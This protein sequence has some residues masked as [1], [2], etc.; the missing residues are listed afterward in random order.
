MITIRHSFALSLTPVVRFLIRM[1]GAG[2]LVGC[3]TYDAP[4]A[5]F[6]VTYG[7]F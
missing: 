4:M 6:C 5:S 1:G 7:R 2:A 3:K